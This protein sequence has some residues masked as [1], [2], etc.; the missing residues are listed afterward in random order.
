MFPN[1]S[2]IIIIILIAIVL[3]V[4]EVCLPKKTASVIQIIGAVG[5]LAYLLAAFSYWEALIC[6]SFGASA[7]ASFGTLLNKDSQEKRLELK[8]RLRNVRH[9]E[10]EQDK[11]GKRILTDFLLTMMVCLGGFLFLVYAP[12]NYVVIKFFIGL[13]FLH[14]LAQ[15]IER[16]GN[17]YSTRL[18]WLP[19]EERL[20]IISIFQSRDFPLQDLRE[21]GLETSPDL[22]KLHPL[23]TFLSSNMDFT[24]SFNP[25]L[26]LAFP[27]E[28]V[29]LTPNDVQKW[30]QLF[31]TYTEEAR[32]D[33]DQPAGR[34]PSKQQSDSA[35]GKQGK[36]VLPLWHPRVLKRLFW[37]GYFAVTVKGVSAYTGLL[38][39]L[40]WLEV[41]P[42]VMVISVLVWWAVNV[43]V[44]D[45]VLIA[46]TDA[47]PLTEGDIYE[48]AENIFRQAGLSRTRL[49]IADSPV[50]NG[51][52]TGMNIG[53]ATVMLTKATLRLPPEAIE[54]ILAHEAVHV[55]KRDILINQIARVVFLGLMAALIYFFFD[56]IQWLAEA[57]FVLFV[58]IIYVLTF[59]YPIYLSFVSQWTEVRADHAGAA[60]LPE[61]PRQMADGLADLAAAQDRDLDKS[62]QYSMANKR[63]PSR[64]RT[65]SVKRDSWIW[66]FLEFQFQPHPPMYWRVAT[67]SSHREGWG[68]TIWKKWMKD[69]F[70]ESFPDRKRGTKRKVL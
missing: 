15:M 22:L 9:E 34:H 54:A 18:Y 28:N 39:I 35:H 25:V 40:I 37:K 10:I 68:M 8:Q 60:F 31:V 70:K 26:K 46:A 63:S 66:R 14:V 51:L 43:Y 53:R 21:I 57:Y 55:Q 17:F 56:Y 24:R 3:S 44:S 67:L 5:I 50:Y 23:F 2:T 13:M 19:E 32:G 38:L 65:S 49:L 58:G 36:E 45:R 11:D 1:L 62:L 6:F 7:F 20:L 69:R 48:R 30:Q 47:Q 33:V 27:G 52:A 59:I 29:Y 42:W 61:G 16:A 12:M 41:P 64:E 4:I